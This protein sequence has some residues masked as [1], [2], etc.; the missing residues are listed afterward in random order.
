MDTKHLVPA[1]QL[2]THYNIELSFIRSLQSFGLIDVVV[3]EETHFIHEAQ[4]R[5]IEQMIRLHYDLDINL[6]GID[7]I[8]HLLKRV[9][10]LQEELA[11]LRNRL[12]VSDSE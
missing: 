6:E 1:Q 8:S 12:Q 10:Q 4:I 2:C 5:D 3:V 9:Q 11:T 7:A